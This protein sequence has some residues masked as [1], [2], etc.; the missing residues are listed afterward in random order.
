MDKN[1]IV[2]KLDPMIGRQFLIAGIEERITGYKFDES[3]VKLISDKRTRVFDEH[4][5][6]SFLRKECMEIGSELDEMG[7]EFDDVMTMAKPNGVARQLPAQVPSQQ[8][9]IPSFSNSHF[10]ELRQVLMSN[11]A[12]V[13]ENKEYLPQAVAVRDNVQS[14]ID[15]TKNEI[16]FMKTVNRIKR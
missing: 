13:Q 11:I 4:Q 5:L 9:Y 6:D 15:L 12:K 7:D 16:D 8:V 2:N 14:I 3:S 10:A 1:K